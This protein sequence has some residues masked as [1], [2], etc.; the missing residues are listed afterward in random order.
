MAWYEANDM[1]YILG[2]SG[3]LAREHLFEPAAEEQLPVVR[4]YP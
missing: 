1:D 2:L 4:G 3:N